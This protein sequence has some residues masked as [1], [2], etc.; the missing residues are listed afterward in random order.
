MVLLETFKFEDGGDYE[1]DVKLIVFSRIPTKLI[2]TPKRF[3][4]LSLTRKISTGTF[5]ARG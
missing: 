3:I 1:G 5:I 2:D 4:V